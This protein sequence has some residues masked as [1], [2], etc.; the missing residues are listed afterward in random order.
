MGLTEKIKSLFGREKEPETE[1]YQLYKDCKRLNQEDIQRFRRYITQYSATAE[2]FKGENE[3]VYQGA[4]ENVQ[5]F[6]YSL[7]EA[8]KT[9]EFIRPNAREDIDY[10]SQLFGFAE[11]LKKVLPSDLD[12][13]FHGTPI[14]FAKEILKSGEISSSADRF[15][16]FD[17]STDG[18]GEFSVSDIDS[19]SRTVNF[20]LDVTAY[21]RSLPCGC[22]FVLTADGQTEKQRAGSLMNRVDFKAEPE[23]LFAIVTTPENI[24][25]VKEWVRE[26]QLSEN[27]VHS[28]GGFVR[29]MEKAKEKFT[30]SKTRLDAQVAGASVKCSTYS[31]KRETM[32][33]TR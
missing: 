21:E 23:R 17:K 14:Y 7:Y 24:S 1:E 4:M 25:Q 19:L 33:I 12:L 32:E 10:R 11:Q 26:S 15:D 28:F 2:R 8:E 27:K 13:R 29:E 3:T 22:L 6:Q 20:F 30:D 18:R 9:T 5:R 16:G 31:S